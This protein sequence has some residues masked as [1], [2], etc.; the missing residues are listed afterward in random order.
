M[1]AR[2][3]V[4]TLI[5]AAESLCERRSR[6]QELRMAGL[7][8][9]PE[10]L[11]ECALLKC[12]LASVGRAAACSK[13]LAALLRDDV[14]WRQ[15]Y[16]LAAERAKI[17]PPL[18]PPPSWR[19]AYEQELLHERFGAFD[20][21]RHGAGDYRILKLLMTGPASV[22]KTTFLK[23]IFE[24]HEVELQELV[25]I[26]PEPVESRQALGSGK[27]NMLDAFYDEPERY[28]YTF[29]NYVFVTR[30]LQESKSR[31]S[32]ATSRRGRAKSQPS[33]SSGAVP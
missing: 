26:V 12:E 32:S 17:A 14:F 19:Q 21:G 1:P 23:K 29:Q 2:R 33:A 20:A 4:R 30:A 3:R 10:E 16:I 24:G 31:A 5:G 22:G 6:P 9:L 27:F 7:L 18:T 25:Q 13:A 28:A 11:I 8:F 15:F